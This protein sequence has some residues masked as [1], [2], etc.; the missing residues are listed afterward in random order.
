ML[1]YPDKYPDLYFYKNF[2]VSGT[3][4]QINVCQ[5]SDKNWAEYGCFKTKLKS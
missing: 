2:L 1:K 3:N 4:Y 5:G